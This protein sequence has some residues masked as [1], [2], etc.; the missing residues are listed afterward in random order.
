[1]RTPRETFGLEGTGRSWTQVLLDLL[2]GTL[3]LTG[4]AVIVGSASSGD[5]IA[6]WVGVG[7]ILIGAVC[8]G[9]N[10]SLAVRAAKREPCNPSR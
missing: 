9:A 8:W 1:M 7:L 3:V 6:I 10:I 2:S 4:I 5:A